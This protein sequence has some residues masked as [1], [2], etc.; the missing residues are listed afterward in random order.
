M[1]SPVNVISAAIASVCSE[2]C[3]TAPPALRRSA[4]NSG[5][6]KPESKIICRGW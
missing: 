5:L 6:R 1:S 3:A 2:A 4:L